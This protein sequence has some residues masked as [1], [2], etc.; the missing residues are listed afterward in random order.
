[1]STAAFAVVVMFAVSA[2]LFAFAAAG[3]VGHHVHHARDFVGC[4]R[5]FLNDDAAEV[6]VLSGTRMVEVD[7]HSVGLHLDDGGAE[8]L[9]QLAIR[10]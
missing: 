2:A 6:E 5:T 10:L 3:V 7:G 4:G 9:S 8:G 1:M